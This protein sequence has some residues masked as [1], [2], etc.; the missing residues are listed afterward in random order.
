MI[1]GGTSV[2]YEGKPIGTPDCGAYFEIIQRLKVNVFY[3]SP[4][5]IRSI[6]K[7]DHELTKIK[8]YDLSSLK[9]VG[10]VG[11]RTDIYT[12]QYL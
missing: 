4:T 7:E 3:T 2:I 11:E 5:A 1:W 12:Y 6:R 10:V 9:V 8:H